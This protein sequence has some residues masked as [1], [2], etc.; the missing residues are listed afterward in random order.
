MIDVTETAIHF[1]DCLELIPELPDGSIDCVVTDPPYGANFVSHRAQ[2]AAGKKWVKP[3]N[4]DQDLE[5]ALAL[6]A[7]V[8]AALE[9]KC[10][11]EVDVYVFT[12][13]DIVGHWIDL[14]NE[15]EWLQYKMM[16]VW[17]KGIPG[18]GD[19]D[20]NW[21]CGHELILY[22]KRGRREVA[23]RR[24]AIIAVNKVHPKHTIH[25]T[26]KPVPL[27][28]KFVEMSTKRGDVVFDPF[29]GSGSTVKAAKNLGRI[30]IG[31]ENDDD[32]YERST[33][34]ISEGVLF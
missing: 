21:G 14:I 27:L 5:S 9:S 23:Y 7:D 34:R 30:G 11:E 3:V 1:G 31:C 29:S 28:E 20:S 32:H 6:F 22:C 15:C 16:L 12:R 25:P 24:S 4:N 26:E 13:W 33:N 18:M 17:D 10:K 2:T 8:L 19:I